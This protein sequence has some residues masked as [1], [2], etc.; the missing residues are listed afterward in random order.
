MIQLPLTVWVC[1]ETD[2]F[3]ELR[4]LKVLPEVCDWFEGGK[5]GLSG[6]RCNAKRA[7]LSYP[8]KEEENE[9]DQGIQ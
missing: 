6:K 1:R 3:T 2:E 5:C 7:N 9:T 4:N 8:K